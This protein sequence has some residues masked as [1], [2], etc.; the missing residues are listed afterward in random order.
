[1]YVLQHL[2]A[3]TRKRRKNVLIKFP[4]PAGYFSINKKALVER[5]YMSIILDLS[6]NFPLISLSFSL[7]PRVI[8][9]IHNNFQFRPKR[10]EI[11]A[12]DINN[13]FLLRHQQ[14]E[15]CVS[16]IIW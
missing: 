15:S 1:M 4:S 12:D 6:R 10:E 9:F 7:N 13:D 14:F 2:K 5:V 8:K 3:D 11:E 16:V